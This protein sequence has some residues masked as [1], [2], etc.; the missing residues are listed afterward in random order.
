MDF[1][2][3]FFVLFF[4]EKK[5]NFLKMQTKENDTWCATVG[6]I[7]IF[8]MYTHPAGISKGSKL[9]GDSFANESPQLKMKRGGGEKSSLRLLYLKLVPSP[10]FGPWRLSRASINLHKV[11]SKLH[12]NH[13]KMIPKKLYKNDEIF[14]SSFIFFSL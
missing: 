4:E 13:L 6:L 7:R 11:Q 1:L 14:K 8:L 12:Y 3:L 9:W 2:F 5:S 10:F